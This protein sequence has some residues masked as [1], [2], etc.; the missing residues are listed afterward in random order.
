MAT[1]K[2]IS[3]PFYLKTDDDTERQL[4]HTLDHTVVFIVSI[5]CLSISGA[6]YICPFFSNCLAHQSYSD[7]VAL[8]PGPPEIESGEILSSKTKYKGYTT[9]KN[10]TV[11]LSMGANVE[12]AKFDELCRAR[13][14]TKSVEVR[15]CRANVP[16][17]AKIKIMQI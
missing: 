8:R 3:R 5:C 6:S 17:I 13:S 15:T 9:N 16:A 11:T 1:G 4:V 7:S 2:G 10:K 14:S 12:Y